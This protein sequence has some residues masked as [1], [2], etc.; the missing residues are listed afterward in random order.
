[1]ASCQVAFTVIALGVMLLGG[2][3]LETSDGEPIGYLS[4]YTVLL[5]YLFLGILSVPFWEGMAWLII[6]PCMWL[7]SKI[8]PITIRYVAHDLDDC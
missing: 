8:R 2:G 1:M 5:L 4:S 3:A 6:Y 7:Y